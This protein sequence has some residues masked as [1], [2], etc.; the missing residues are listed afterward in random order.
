MG[1]IVIVSVCSVYW[2]PLLCIFL[3]IKESLAMSRIYCIKLGLNSVTLT[4]I[5][6]LEGKLTNHTTS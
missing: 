6:P 2:W 4:E 3:R 5:R 1:T